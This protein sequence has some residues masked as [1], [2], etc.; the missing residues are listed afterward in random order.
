MHIMAAFYFYLANL[1]K[2]NQTTGFL[3]WLMLFLMH[4]CK[5]FLHEM[6]SAFR[7]RTLSDWV[8]GFVMLLWVAGGNRPDWFMTNAPVYLLSNTFYGF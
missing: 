1:L 7:V 5:L 6:L 8:G 3:P 4:F 2:K